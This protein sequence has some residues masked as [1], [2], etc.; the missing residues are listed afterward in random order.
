LIIGYGWLTVVNARADYLVS[1]LAFNEFDHRLWE[2]GPGSVARN[3]SITKMVEISGLFLLFFAAVR[4]RESGVWK[5]LLAILPLLGVVVTFVGIAHRVMDARSIW[6]EEG[7]RL[8][9]TFFAPYVYNGSAGAFL[10]L[11]GA[12]AFSFWVASFW[13]SSRSKKIGWGIVTVICFLG[14]IATASK[15]SFLMLLATLALS[16]LFHRKRLV[17]FWPEFRGQIMGRGVEGKLI[18]IC[19]TA[20]IFAFAAVGVPRLITRMDNLIEDAQDG[21]ASTVDGRLGIMRV[22]LKMS[23]L[24]EGGFGGFGPGSFE[25]VVPYFFVDKD[26]FLPG[27]WINGHSDPL[28]LVVEWGYV[29]AALWLVFGIGGLVNAMNSLK[30][31]GDADSPPLVRGMMIALIVMSIHSAFDFPFG[32]LSV[33]CAAI[34]LLGLLWGKGYHKPRKADRNLGRTSN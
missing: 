7:Q 31:Q 18:L 13:S 34:F 2:S 4:A 17:A 11:A 33:K 14:V 30:K 10:N 22:M 3:V 1:D 29:G 28:Q 6:F 20:I 12:T 9:E 8:P 21:S 23:S 19:V 16:L 26:Y 24:D 27:R 25:Y 32:I 15:G 5:L